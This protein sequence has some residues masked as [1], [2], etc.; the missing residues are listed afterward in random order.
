MTDDKKPLSKMVERE[1]SHFCHNAGI[2]IG[3]N[4]V[5][6]VWG[7]GDSDPDPYIESEVYGEI[8]R[9]FPDKL[10]INVHRIGVE[11]VEPQLMVFQVTLSTKS[12]EWLQS[13]GTLELVNT[14]LRGVSASASLSSLGVMPIPAISFPPYA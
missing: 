4:N 8:S 11:G 10:F 14:F 9:R 7:D 3:I 2:N 12:G 6:W 5:L 13:F 1:F